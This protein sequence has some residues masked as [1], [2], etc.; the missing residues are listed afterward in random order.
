VADAAAFFAFLGDPAAMR[1]THCHASL[2]A[3]RRRLAGFEWQRRRAGI[4]PWAVIAK[5]D[6]RLIGWGGLYEDPFDP[7]WGMEL[8]YALHPAAWGQGYASELASVC[9]DCA[10]TVLRI[11]EVSAFV[12][13]DNTASRRVLEKVG[14]V[15]VRLVPEMQRLLLRRV[16]GGG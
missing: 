11:P 12:H 5:A 1:F 2:R 3:C 9:L 16:S 13:P 14:F 7:G 10:D 4:A 15:P 8:G 6:Q